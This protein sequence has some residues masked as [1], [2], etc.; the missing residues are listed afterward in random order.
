MNPAQR[1]PALGDAGL[2]IGRLALGAIF[3]AHGWQKFDDVG[4]AAVTKNFEAMD[5]P[6][7]SLS[8]YF[9]TWVELVGGIALILGVLVPV[10]GALLAFNMAGAFW[11]AHSDNGLWLDKGGYEYVLALGATALLLALIGGGRFSVDALVWG[12]RETPERS[13]VAA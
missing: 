5:I 12:R 10:A 13:T 9:A 7:A 4:H 8:A 1:I 3:I 6:L 2:L 11:F